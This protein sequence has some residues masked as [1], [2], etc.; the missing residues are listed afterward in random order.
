MEGGGPDAPSDLRSF[1]GRRSGEGALLGEVNLPYPDTMTFF[2]TDR[3]ELTMCFDFIG[4]QRMYLSLARGNAES[5]AE[6]LRQRPQPPKDAHWATFVR[7]HDELTL[8]KLTDTQRQEVFEAFGP[9]PDMQ[10]YGRGLRRRLP[11]MLGGDRDR[12]RMV[13]SLL[14]SMPGTPVLFYGEEIGMGE[15]LRAEGRLAVRTPMPWLAGRNGGF[16]TADRSELPG[17]IPDGEYGPE[18]VNVAAQERDPGALLCW[19]RLLIESYRRCPELAWGRYEV[20]DAGDSAVLAHR[21]DTEGGTVLA[22]HNFAAVPKK[23][24]LKLAGLDAS[25]VLSDVLA[26]GSERVANDGSVVVQLGR[27]S[28]RWLRVEHDLR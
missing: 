18:R 1:L 5:L 17:P 13:Y 22:V 6:A 28:C 23:A 27:Y 4:M 7:N 26:D 16:S 20:L 8:D 14:F 3:D 9:D 11:T 2:G 10:L 21:C 25:C 19:V 15:D 24:A 12:I